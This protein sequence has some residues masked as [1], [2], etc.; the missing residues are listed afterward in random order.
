MSFCSFC[1]KEIKKNNT[2]N[3][4]CGKCK[5]RIYCSPECQKEDWSGNKGQNHKFW[6][7]LTCEENEDYKITNVEGKGLGIIAIKDIKKDTRIIVDKAYLYDEFI[8]SIEDKFKNLMPYDGTKKD[9]FHLNS[10][11]GKDEGYENSYIA[12]RISRVNHSCDG[13]VDHKYIKEYNVIVLFS[14]KDILKG[15]ELNF[16]YISQFSKY[17]DVA[18]YYNFNDYDTNSI[19]KYKWNIECSEYCICKNKDF[20]NDSNLAKKLDDE[21]L[22]VSY[23]RDLKKALKKVD[24]LIKIYKK[25]NISL[26]LERTLYD[27]FQISIMKKDTLPKSDGY[28]NEL[29]KVNHIWHHPESKYIKKFK[30]YIENNH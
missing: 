11:N 30:S 18:N 13:N 10:I 23:D 12:P 20:L 21:I 25:Y 22:Q 27:G 16:P 29:I 4:K 15:D 9:K 3:G 5:K 8:K 26:C 2:L 1:I 17:P 28:L 24:N 7:G 6:C 19:L 14:T